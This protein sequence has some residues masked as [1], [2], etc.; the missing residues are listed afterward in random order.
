MILPG[1]NSGQ[2][3]L[4]KIVTKGTSNANGRRADRQCV[5]RWN[6]LV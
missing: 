5:F 2:E 4:G 3:E 1:G 6:W